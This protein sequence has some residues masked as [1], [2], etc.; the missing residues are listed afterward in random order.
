MNVL[1]ASANIASMSPGYTRRP[2][3]TTASPPHSQ[4]TQPVATSGTKIV[5]PSHLNSG[6]TT[7][8]RGRKREEKRGEREKGGG[9]K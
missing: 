8:R 1:R 6:N 9:I 4:H 5:K 2:T 7:A 3:S